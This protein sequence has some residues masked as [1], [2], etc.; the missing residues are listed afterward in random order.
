[1]NA[2]DKWQPPDDPD[3]NEI[4]YSAVDD[5][6]AGRHEAALAKFVWFHHNA[7]SVAQSL[8]AV[9]LSFALSDWYDLAKDYPPAMAAMLDA[10]DQAEFSFLN[11]G[12]Q[13]EQFADLSALNRTLG[14]PQRTC[15]IF[16]QVMQNDNEAAAR[17]YHVAE[18]ALVHQK[19]FALCNSFLQPAKRLES[20]LMIYKVTR[21]L[22]TSRVN[23]PETA[24]KR[25]VKELSTLVALLVVNHRTFEAETVAIDAQAALPDLPL[26]SEL[27][28][29]LSGQLP[30]ARPS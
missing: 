25:L 21:Q 12:Y 17:V 8:S 1:M 14:T 11:A 16:K 23:F 3:P 30:P 29:A 4:L 20:A 27:A 7:L 26:K 28:A 6:R 10:R 24:Y 22:E 13:Y 2:I 18:S 19:E 5:A 15:S 9:R